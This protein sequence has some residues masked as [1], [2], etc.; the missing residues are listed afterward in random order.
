MNLEDESENEEWKKMTNVWLHN[1]GR[2]DSYVINAP[3]SQGVMAAFNLREFKVE[4]SKGRYIVVDYELYDFRNSARKIEI[5]GERDS[6]EGALSLAYDSAKDW[7][8]ALS[9]KY[10]IRYTEGLKD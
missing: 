10:G 2:S 4:E 1:Y 8:T 9:S 6:R 3:P 5:K 7:A